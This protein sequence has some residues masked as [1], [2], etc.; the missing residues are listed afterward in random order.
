MKKPSSYSDISFSI[1]TYDDDADSWY[2]EYIWFHGTAKRTRY[3]ICDSDGNHEP[4]SL[5]EMNL[6]CDQ[7]HQLWLD[8]SAWVIERNGEDPIGEFIVKRDRKFKRNYVAHFQH[9][10]GERDHGLALTGVRWAGGLARPEELPE[11]F[12]Q[13]LCLKKVGNRWCM[14]GITTDVLKDSVGYVGNGY[15]K[16]TAEWTEALPEETIRKAILKAARKHIRNDKMRKLRDAEILANP[17]PKGC[18]IEQQEGDDK[19]TFVLRFVCEEGEDYVSEFYFTL[20]GESLREAAVRVCRQF[21]WIDNP[22]NR[23]GK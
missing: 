17:L 11:G 19:D 12:Q 1:P 3:T 20:P 8:Y 21:D 23:A 7:E 10:I 22:P 18:E 6:L 9:W 16:G 15:F 5:K 13:F 14:D 2:Q 4:L